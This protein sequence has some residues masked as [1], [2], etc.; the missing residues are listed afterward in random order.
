MRPLLIAIAGGTASG[1]TTIA[2]AFASRTGALLLSH[3][4]YYRDGLDPSFNFDHPDALE[5]TLLVQHLDALTRGESVDLP[6]Y[7][8]GTHRRA[9]RREIVRPRP[10]VVVEGI[11]VL[12][13]PALATRFDL[14]VFVACPD[15]VRLLRRMVRDCGERDRT[16]FSVAAQ[17][18]ATV[19]PMHQQ[20]VAP[21]EA[22]AML[23]LDGMNATEVEVERLVRATGG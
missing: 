13:E 11:L 16:V 22:R 5:T 3:D 14:T 23:V 8:F 20:F 19:R 18:L 17:Y 15:D 21:C 12:S 6:V 10:V 1:K 7:D 4:R 9:E 2:H